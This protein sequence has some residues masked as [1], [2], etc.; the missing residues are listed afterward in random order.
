MLS[1]LGFRERSEQR[2]SE[3]ALFLAPFFDSI[4]EASSSPPASCRKILPPIVNHTT[5]AANAI[6][7]WR[8]SRVG[9]RPPG[10]VIN[11]THNASH[12]IPSHPIPSRLIR[13]LFE[14]IRRVSWM[15]LAICISPGRPRRARVRSSARRRRSGEKKTFLTY[16]GSIASGKQSIANVPYSANRQKEPPRKQHAVTGRRWRRVYRMAPGRDLCRGPTVTT[17]IDR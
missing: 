16:Q 10:C 5:S 9:V 15:A 11:E 6:H 1:P 4:D 17:L 3:R 12:R 13:S 14:A 2:S 8:Y 7:A